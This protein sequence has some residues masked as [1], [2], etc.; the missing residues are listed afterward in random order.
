[1]YDRKQQGSIASGTHVAP[2]VGMLL[3]NNSGVG[4]A[5]RRYAQVYEHLKQRNVSVV[6]AINQSLFVELS[7]AGILKDTPDLVVKEWT[8][9]LSRYL[10]AEST[11]HR[12]G[13]FA[14]R[15]LSRAAFVL[16]KLDYAIACLP[17]AVWIIRR[18]PNVL[19]LI[20]GGAYVALPLQLAGVGPPAMISMVC[21]SL[22]AMVGSGL[23]YRLYRVALRC[24]SAVDALTDSVR[25]TL[26]HEG[27]PRTSIRV[28]PGSCVNT[29]RFT[30]AIARYPWVVFAGRLI[31]EKNPDQFVTVCSRIHDSI[32]NAKFFILGDGPLRRDVW[33]LVKQYGLQHHTKMMWTD[34]I[35]SVLQYALVFVS[36]QRMD[37]YPSQA[38]LEAMSCGAA[39]VATDVGQTEKLVDESVGKLVEPTSEAIARAVVDLL[40]NSDQAIL[41]GKK[42]RLRVL[43]QHSTDAYV[44]YL[45]RLYADLSFGG[46]RTI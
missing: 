30:P 39:V 32:P 36:M 34:H 3:F 13:N 31:S 41:K 38:L 35:E 22:R 19:H 25:E 24:A 9:G 27:I 12:R 21:P 28:S 7:R 45:L 23:A 44:D 2:Q 29:T 8:T 37:N 16:R 6:L 26:M 15:I 11:V 4:G 43:Q 10:F 1:M 14:G 33:T 17:V 5:E 18:H 42:A 40:Q 46:A 20:L